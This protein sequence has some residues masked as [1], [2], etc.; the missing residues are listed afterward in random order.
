[1][2]NNNSE[3]KRRERTIAAAGAAFGVIIV[4]AA[5]PVAADIDFSPSIKVGAT[6]TD[7]I[8]LAPASQS[9]QTE[10]VAEVVPGF[11]LKQEGRRLKSQLSY[12]L[13]NFFYQKDSSRDTSFHEANASVNA[14]VL[15]NWFFV[16]VA[17]GYTQQI[18]DPTR[19]IN[20]NFLFDVGNLTDALSGSVTP[21][22]RHEFDFTILDASYER[23]FLDYKQSGDVTNLT[24]D[25]DT[26]ET[27]VS[28]VSPEDGRL[29]SWGADYS[30]QETEFDT[31][32]QRFEFESANL[33]LGI[34]LTNELR[35][36]GRAGK[37]TDA[38]RNSA[39][40]GLDETSWE[41][42]FAYS[43]DPGT[44]LEA[45]YGKRFFGTSY[46]ASARRT[47][48]F[49]TLSASYDEGPV[50]QAQQLLAQAGATPVT[51]VTPIA[52]L[53][54]GTN[55]TGTLTSDVYIAKNFDGTIG[56]AGR[57]TKISISALNQRREYLNTHQQERV[58]G[59]RFTVIRNLS[60]RTDATFDVFLTDTQFRSGAA[61]DEQSYR[62]SL[63]RTLSE[64]LSASFM[65]GR[66]ERSGSSGY[67]ANWVNIGVTAS[68]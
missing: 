23:G 65:L 11:V 33:E 2:H 58:T 21:R 10:Y 12:T 52:P 45:F 41:A 20:N 4:G 63:T 26:Q 59:G 42:G 56:L 38:R 18:I 48:Q 14:E 62:F 5:T 67:T 50:T 49:L 31:N 40:G 16:D 35:L 64:R 15:R 43:P 66:V 51:P 9:E 61:F 55:P 47:A 57:L 28:L 24:S 44:K 22:L 17:G 6:W 1:M 37:E 60:A 53:D 30:K 3:A 25:A 29:I 13:R 68:Y 54:P 34:G 39:Q 8:E 36:I 27:R 32:A 46:R 19:P 7:N